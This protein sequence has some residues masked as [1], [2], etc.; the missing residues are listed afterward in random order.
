MTGPT[1]WL[2]PFPALRAFHAAARHARFRDA[3]EELGV[4][5]SAVSHQI[6]KLE[7]FLRV[8]LF[9]RS[10]SGVRLTETGSRYFEEI[11]P[12]FERIE[13]ASRRLV[14][15][16]G[17]PRVVLTLPPSMAILW[18]VPA[19]AAFERACPDIDLQ[20]MTTVRVCNLRRE[21]IDLAIRHGRGDW[22]DVEASFMFAETAVP[23]CAPGYLGDVDPADP[24]AAL[25]GARLIVNKLHPPEWEEWAAAHGLPAPDAGNALLLEGLEQGLQAA[26]AG[27]GIAMGRRPLVDERLEQGRIVAP[28][29]LRGPSDAAYYLCHPAGATPS[30]PARDVTRWLRALAV[31]VSLQ[32]TAI[33]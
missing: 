12:A 28:F 17:R 10:R 31:D 26:E 21:Q 1:R 7:D 3:A 23:V 19:L 13:A 32:I 15:P 27:L 30:R 14:G 9:E 11:E 18:L 25:A 20:L 29:G 22:D 6:R 4:T 24:S 2:P 5:E 16:I 33:T 8:P